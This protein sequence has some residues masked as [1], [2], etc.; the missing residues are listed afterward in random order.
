MGCARIFEWLGVG[1]TLRSELQY[2]GCL[3][4]AHWLIQSCTSCAHGD[5]ACSYIADAGDPFIAAY[6]LSA[7]FV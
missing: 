3:H 5:L 7:T 1:R 6:H 2:R 4:S